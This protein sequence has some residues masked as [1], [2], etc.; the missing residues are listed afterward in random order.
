MQLKSNKIKIPI[1][2]IQQ[3]LICKATGEYQ[4]LSEA[5]SYSKFCDEVCTENSMECAQMV[6][7]LLVNFETIT[8]KRSTDFLKC[9]ELRIIAKHRKCTVVSN[10]A[11]KTDEFFYIFSI[12]LNF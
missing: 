8:K 1:F 7:K 11:M 3:N 9:S 12:Y 5:E 2:A 10:T 6:I 4:S